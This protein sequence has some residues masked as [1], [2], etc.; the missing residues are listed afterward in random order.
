MVSVRVA[1]VVSIGVAVALVVS[2]SVSVGV[3]V[4]VAVAVVVCAGVAVL[5][6]CAGVAVL[7]LV[8]RELL[9]ERLQL[10][11]DKRVI[12]TSV[13]RWALTSGGTTPQLWLDCLLH[14]FPSG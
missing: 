11:W 3:A 1:V 5:L 2:I 4:G 9:R 13:L 10:E 6:V 12:R 8:E 14:G 7:L